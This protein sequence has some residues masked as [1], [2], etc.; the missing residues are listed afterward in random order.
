M[1]RRKASSDYAT[2]EQP[3][4]AIKRLEVRQ[5]L[6]TYSLRGVL[7]IFLVFEIKEDPAARS[8]FSEIIA[9]ISDVKFSHSGRYIATR[10]Y[11][12]INVRQKS[13]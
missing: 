11:L 2:H 3:R 1:A 12:T 7:M 10:D 13:A 9:S 5:I 6:P 8:F 4:S